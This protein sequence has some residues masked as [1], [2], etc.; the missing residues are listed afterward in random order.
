MFILIMWLLWL[1][2]ISLIFRDCYAIWNRKIV[3]YN[4][5]N[6]AIYVVITRCNV[7][8]CWMLK[9]DEN[10]GKIVTWS[11]KVNIKYLSVT[12]HWY[13]FIFWYFRNNSNA[14]VLI[15]FDKRLSIVTFN[16]FNNKYSNDSYCIVCIEI[17]V[18]VYTYYIC[19]QPKC[20]M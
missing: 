11:R 17:Y 7:E 9:L 16:Y 15:N 2:F 8:R 1:E 13:Y 10:K 18:H 14:Y 12:I 6:I 20:E 5:W 19:M 3:P 4:K